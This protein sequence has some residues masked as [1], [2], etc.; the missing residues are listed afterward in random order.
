MFIEMAKL[1]GGFLFKLTIVCCCI[2]RIQ[3]GM[4]YVAITGI[5]PGAKI[6]EAKGNAVFTVVI[7]SKG[8][9]PLKSSTAS[10]VTL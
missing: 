9:P 1:F 4:S 3:V 7:V 10:L 2:S 8:M 6:R 5:A